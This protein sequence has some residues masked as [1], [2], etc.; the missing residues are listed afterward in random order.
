[1]A[2]IFTAGVIILSRILKIVLP[3]A[4]YSYMCT[5]YNGILKACGCNER[6]NSRARVKKNCASK[7]DE[8]AGANFPACCTIVRGGRSSGKGV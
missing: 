6:I 2:F 8:D 3:K 1:M 7:V 5:K 4:K